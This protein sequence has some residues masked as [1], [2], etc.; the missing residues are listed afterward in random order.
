M[1]THP[2]GTRVRCEMTKWGDRLHWQFEGIH[3]GSDEHGE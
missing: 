1:S 2:P 3:L